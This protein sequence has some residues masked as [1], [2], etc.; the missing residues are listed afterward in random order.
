ME[1]ASPETRIILLDSLEELPFG[2]NE[3]D[4][5]NCVVSFICAFSPTSTPSANT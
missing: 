1:S 3:S 5:V 4:L 2:E